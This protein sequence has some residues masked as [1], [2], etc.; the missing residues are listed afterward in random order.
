MSKNV[1]VAMQTARAMNSDRINLARYTFKD[2]LYKRRIYVSRLT[3]IKKPGLFTIVL[4][5]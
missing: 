4:I 3:N 5:N 1:V 2:I